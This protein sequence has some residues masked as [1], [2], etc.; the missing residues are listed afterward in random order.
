MVTTFDLVQLLTWDFLIQLLTWDFQKIQ[1]QSL[2]LAYVYL[3]ASYP[4]LKNYDGKK[5]RPH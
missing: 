1:E 5:P 4:S 3:L 2:N